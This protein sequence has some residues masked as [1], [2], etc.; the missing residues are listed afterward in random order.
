MER[1]DQEGGERS[2]LEQEE[3]L[4]VITSSAVSS[5]SLHVTFYCPKVALLSS[6]SKTDTIHLCVLAQWVSTSREAGVIK[7]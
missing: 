5:S 2:L 6:S 7:S 1:E 3:M 4:K